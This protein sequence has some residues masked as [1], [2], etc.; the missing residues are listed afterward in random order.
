VTE[1]A[2]RV[3]LIVLCMSLSPMLLLAA[4]GAKPAS[5]PIGVIVQADRALLGSEHAIGGASVFDGDTLGTESTGSLNFRFGASQ[6]FLS[7]A[8]S[9][10]FHRS[11]NGFEAD[12]TNGTIVFSVKEGEHFGLVADGAQ[13]HA[14]TAQATIAQVTKVSP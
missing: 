5:A 13:I 10:V 2:A 12:L 8:S 9:A 11:D 1:R 6:A 14:G 4:P 7:S 3:L